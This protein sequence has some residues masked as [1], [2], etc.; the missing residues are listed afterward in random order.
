MT[1]ISTAK[2]KSMI[3][4]RSNSPSLSVSLKAM[5]RGVERQEYNKTTVM[6]RSQYYL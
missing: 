5:F 3:L 6:K 4:S 1:R 2:K